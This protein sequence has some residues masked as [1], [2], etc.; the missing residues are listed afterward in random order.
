MK[1]DELRDTTR[2]LALLVRLGL[3]LSDGL[4]ALGR[5]SVPM[6]RLAQQVEAGDSL[7]QAVR[8]QPQHFSPFFQAMVAAAEELP[9][10]EVTLGQLSRWLERAEVVRTR[11]R[12]ALL[13][14]GLVLSTILLEL[15][16]LLLVVMPALLVP[17][18]R[19]AHLPGLVQAE[20]PARVLGVVVLL[21]LALLWMPG[22]GA[23]LERLLP[24]VGGLIPL[25]E[26]AVWARALGALIGVGQPL[27]AAVERSAGVVLHAG[28]RGELVALADDLSRG[29]RLAAFT[30]PWLD[31][32]LAWGLA[33]GEDRE[34]L[35][36]LLGE[37]ADE[38]E[39]EL[40]RRAEAVLASLQPALL[41]ALG[42][43]SLLVMTA[44]WWPYYYTVTGIGPQ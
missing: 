34:E 13:Y 31:P 20:L 12:S 3:P 5:Q 26:Q 40:D 2:Q 28:R 9:R 15:A 11:L 1:P 32:I 44:F 36:T 38:L 18:A 21:G 23:R 6:A 43:F 8:R 22:R 7:A 17:L 19:V 16:A 24:R 39:A 10:P 37:V 30:P 41:A 29:G 25:A 14:P 4:H 33:S 27:P 42:L 35:A